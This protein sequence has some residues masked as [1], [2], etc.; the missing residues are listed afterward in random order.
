MPQQAN[1]YAADVTVTS[2]GEVV[3]LGILA[4]HIR[5]ENRGGVPIFFTL[6]STS[7]ASTSDAR[8]GALKVFEADIPP[9][10]FIGFKTTSTATSTS[11]E[12]QPVVGV[13]AV[14]G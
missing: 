7:P 5:I 13:I 1:Q 11:D 6:A 14:G 10:E 9:V 2:T 4:R 8:L 3:T 12:Q